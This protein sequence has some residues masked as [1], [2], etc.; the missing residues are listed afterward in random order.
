MFGASR[1]EFNQLLGRLDAL[2]H[3]LEDMATN[4]RATRE[5]HYGVLCRLS[6]KYSD[7]ADGIEKSGLMHYEEGESGWRK[8]PAKKGK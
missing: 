2:R 3:D 6:K 1:K 5:S 8:G 7:L 4:L